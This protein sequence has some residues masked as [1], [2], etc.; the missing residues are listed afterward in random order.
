MIEVMVLVVAFNAAEMVSHSPLIVTFTQ[1]PLTYH[2]DLSRRVRACPTRLQ[3]SC[4]N[5]S[6]TTDRCEKQESLILVFLLQ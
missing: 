5:I 4:K 2:L 3:L 1:F 6:R